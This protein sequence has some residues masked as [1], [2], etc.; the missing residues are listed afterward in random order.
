MEECLDPDQTTNTKQTS[1]AT[2][3]TRHH[4][5]H[6]LLSPQ[7]QSLKSHLDDGSE[8]AGHSRHSIEIS[9][10]GVVVLRRTLSVQN[11][12]TGT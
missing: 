7:M 12:I 10:A 3:F 8:L 5:L 4:S 11:V 6:H 1:V 2:H 9:V